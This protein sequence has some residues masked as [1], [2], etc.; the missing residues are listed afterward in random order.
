[1]S[2]TGPAAMQSVPVPSRWTCALDRR[3]EG[4]C[5]AH[6]C[7]P[8]GSVVHGR[9]RG[10]PSREARTKASV[11]NAATTGEKDEEN[12]RKEADDEAEDEQTGQK[13]DTRLTLINQ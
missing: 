3:K 7:N 1:M 9:R 4:R 2:S 13:E 8:A 10:G 12:A 5:A 6:A 11:R